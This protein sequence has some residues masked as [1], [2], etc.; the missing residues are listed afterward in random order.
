MNEVH[1]A[2]QGK[3]GIGKSLVCQFLGEYLNA[4]CIDADP[5][6]RTLS[7]CR[8]LDVRAHDLLDRRKSIDVFAI[9]ALMELVIEETADVVLDIG[10]SSYVEVNAYFAEN[11]LERVF[12][13]AGKVLWV[14]LVVVGGPSQGPCLRSVTDR[15][16]ADKDSARVCIWENEYLG[17]IAIQNESLTESGILA[18][19]GYRHVILP[20]RGRLYVRELEGMVGNGET[21]ADAIAGAATLLSKSRLEQQRDELWKQLDAAFEKVEATG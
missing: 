3:G 12:K 1:I 9:D 19:A 11:E 15:I 17:P 21:F 16:K 4:V 8:S 18:D 20:Q 6:N 2:L 14:H 13:T 5:E 10:A 7:E